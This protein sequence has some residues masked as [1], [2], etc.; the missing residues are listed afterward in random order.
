MVNKILTH[1]W[2]PNF[3]NLLVLTPLERKVQVVGMAKIMCESA[4]VSARETVSTN[5]L[6][7]RCERRG[8]TGV[9]VNTSVLVDVLPHFFP[10]V[11]AIVMLS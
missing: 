5:R 8:C 9:G 1:V 3:A 7:G 4:E 10:V 11:C 6:N 2:I